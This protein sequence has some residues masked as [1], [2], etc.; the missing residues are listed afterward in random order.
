VPVFCHPQHA[1]RYRSV[2]RFAFCKKT[3]VLAEAARRIA[4]LAEQL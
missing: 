2:L 3:E 1:D 4:T